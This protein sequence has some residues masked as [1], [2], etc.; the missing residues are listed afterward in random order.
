MSKKFE[1]E[2]EQLKS[3]NNILTDLNNQPEPDHNL[4]SEADAVLEKLNSAQKISDLNRARLDYLQ[5]S[6]SNLEKC[7]K[8]KENLIKVLE[9]Q[10]TTVYPDHSINDREIKILVEERGDNETKTY[11]LEEETIEQYAN[12][13]TEYESQNQT[14]TEIEDDEEFSII[15]S[16]TDNEILPQ[17]NVRKET[18]DNNSLMSL[19]SSNTSENSNS[20]EVM[21]SFLR[22]KRIREKALEKSKNKSGAAAT[23]ALQQEYTD[24]SFN[25]VFNTIHYF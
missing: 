18:E 2:S 4:N 21:A 25:E 14:I 24:D 12:L 15:S 10:L 20:H 23:E 7:L 8:E 9:N 6:H 5:V 13:G 11:M 3:L 16:I 19:E 22:Y 1:Y 17:K